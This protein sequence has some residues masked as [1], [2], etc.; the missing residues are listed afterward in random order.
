MNDDKFAIFDNTTSFAIG[1]IASASTREELCR[2]LSVPT[3]QDELD[4]IVL[5][6]G[7]AETFEQ[8]DT[9]SS[10]YDKAFLVCLDKSVSTITRMVLPDYIARSVI[11]KTGV[12]L[13]K[14]E[15]K[16]ND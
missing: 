4:S 10:I 8:Q 6:K 3:L 14:K 13:Q 16:V 15:G 12:D 5:K 9:I 7:N 1:A 2:E 11:F